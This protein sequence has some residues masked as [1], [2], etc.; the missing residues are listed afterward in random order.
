MKLEQNN[1]ENKAEKLWQAYQEQNEDQFWPN[2]QQLIRNS[3]KRQKTSAKVVA[4]HA[5]LSH[6]STQKS[7]TKRKS[8][9]S[10]K[11]ILVTLLVVG[12]L[13]F[14][15]VVYL[16]SH[17]ME[18]QTS[19]YVHQSPIADTSF[20]E[21]FKHVNL[22]NPTKLIEDT[23]QLSERIRKLQQYP[24][25]NQLAIGQYELEEDLQLSIERL[26]TCEIIHQKRAKALE[27][28]EKDMLAQA[29]LL[30]SGDSEVNK[31]LRMIRSFTEGVDWDKKPHNLDGKLAEVYRLF[32]PKDTAVYYCE[33]GGLIQRVIEHNEQYF[34]ITDQGV[35]KLTEPLNLYR[36]NIQLVFTVNNYPV[37]ITKKRVV[38]YKKG[39][40][41]VFLATKRN[42]K[43]IKTQLNIERVY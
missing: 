14:A 40:N 7:T 24:D 35:L 38:Y 12:L 23:A 28:V 17:S 19:A 9:Y 25:S 37:V 20:K 39:E 42:R 13:F 10:G 5:V 6:P 2:Y 18:S 15:M 16:T 32:L 27:K 21:F 26:K 34:T 33:T 22:A 4:A 11:D 29:Q 36:A 41:L 31:V 8:V 43:Y 30:A 3:Q 1:L